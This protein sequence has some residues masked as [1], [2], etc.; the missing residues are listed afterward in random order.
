MDKA[1]MK[2]RRAAGIQAQKVPSPISNPENKMLPQLSYG[3]F[4]ELANEVSHLRR[5][6]LTTVTLEQNAK[7]QL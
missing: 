4:C 6:M 3:M 7:R 5:R 1:F 2:A